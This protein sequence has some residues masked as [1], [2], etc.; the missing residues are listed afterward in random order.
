MI[1][2]A[3]FFSGIAVIPLWEVPGHQFSYPVQYQPTFRNGPNMEIDSLVLYPLHRQDYVGDM[4]EEITVRVYEFTERIYMDS[5]IIPI[6]D[7]RGKY[8]PVPLVE[9]S[10]IPEDATTLDILIEDQD[11]LD[12]F[13]AIRIRYIPISEM[14]QYSRIIST[15]CTLKLNRLPRRELWP[16]FILPMQS[17][18]LALKY[19]NDS[20]QIDST[21]GREYRWSQFYHRPITLPEDQYF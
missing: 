16:G 17:S 5:Y 15:D 20:T 1:Q 2:T 9:K 8:N 13:L 10:F 11:F 18:R 4:N 21:E 14:I 7:L 6:I 12:K 3:L 19:A